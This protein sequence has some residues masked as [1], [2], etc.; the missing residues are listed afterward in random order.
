MI[1]SS[2]DAH[3]AKMD[4]LED[5][6]AS[7]EKTRLEEMLGAHKTWAT[8]RNRERVREILG[9]QETPIDP[10]GSPCGTDTTAA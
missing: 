10:V 2:H 1:H 3:I 8:Q 7:E 5:E 9:L 4:A 6:L